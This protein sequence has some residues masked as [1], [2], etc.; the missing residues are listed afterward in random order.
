[1]GYKKIIVNIKLVSKT[2]DKSLTKSEFLRKEFDVNIFV[3]MQW[4]KLSA[5]IFKIFELF[6]K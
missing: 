1:M 2:Y 4:N 6:L 3:S 5:I